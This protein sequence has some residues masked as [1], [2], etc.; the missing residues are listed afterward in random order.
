MMRHFSPPWWARNP[1]VQ[2]ILPV[3]TKAGRP[4]LTRQRLELSDG[5]FIDLDWLGQPKA[6]QPI[7]IIIH[8]LEGG[9]ESHY[10]R[11]LLNDCDLNSICAVVHHHRSCSGETNRRA[12][13]YHSGDTQDLQENLSQLRL[14]YPDS[15]LLA[16]GYSLGG[17]VLTKYLGE[18]ANASLITRAVVVSAPLQ[19]SACAK[20]LESGFSK[21]YQSYL[22]KQLRHKAAEKV[23]NPQL[24]QDMPVSLSQISQLHTF[25]DFDHR[26]TA[27]LHG[28][29]GVD[30]YYRSASGMDFLQYIQKPTL[31]IHAADDPF[32]TADVIPS[33]EQCANQVTYELHSQ[34]GHV[35]FIDGGTPFK[36]RYY[37]EQ[38]ILHFLISQ[39]A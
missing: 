37:L 30:D 16:V 10:V 23:N 3:L 33:A 38:R 20:R 19:L 21:V 22:I 4:D 26:V 36:P 28:F 34:G 5:D 11:R 35:G 14:K 1:H 6:Q 9:S 12:R 17:N 8:G 24:S 27:P 18:N 25:Y 13:S 7:V 39:E 15:P 31:V 29:D 32:M 2:T